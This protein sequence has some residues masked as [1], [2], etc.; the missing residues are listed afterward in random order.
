[1]PV[2]ADGHLDPAAVR[3]AASQETA[4]IVVNTPNNP[5]GAV[6]DAETMRAL[7]DVAE[8]VDALLVSDEVYDHFDYS[9]RFASALGVDS[10]HRAVTTAF[11]KSFAITG[12]RVGY[13]VF[14]PAIADRARTRHMLT[15]VTGSRPAQYAVL[16]ALRTTTPDYYADVRATLRDRI[17][18][19]TDAL[20]D[21][22]ADYTDPEGAFY[23]LARFPDF[24]GTM[25]N[26]E[27]LIEEAGVAGM[28]GETFGSREEWIR[29]ALVTPRADEAAQRLAAFF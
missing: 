29:F 26:V 22:G 6:Y 19:F 1:V 2:E 23:V 21:I 4:C 27:C 20:D 13:A 18:R 3:E 7:V 11:S 12:F 14:P 8:D 16:N 5:T 28:P 15:N 10:A 9:G 25:A 17:G 24:P